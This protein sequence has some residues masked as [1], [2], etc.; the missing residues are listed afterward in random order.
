MHRH[1]QRQ[2][3]TTL[4]T[5]AS[6][7]TLLALPMFLVPTSAEETIYERRT[8]EEQRHT[9]EVAPAPVVKERTIV[10]AQPPVAEKRTTETIV[11][12]GDKDD[13]DDLESDNDND[14][15]DDNDTTSR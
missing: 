8:H 9:L 5:F 2:R 6:L 7:A 14:D 3:Q 13:I 1:K 4:T 15:D 12:E 11:R 10:E